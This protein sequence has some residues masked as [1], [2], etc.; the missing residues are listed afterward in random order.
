MN[1]NHRLRYLTWLPILR[2][3]RKTKLWQSCGQY[4]VVGATQG[5]RHLQGSY[6]F[7]KKIQ[8]FP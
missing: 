5:I 4:A 3:K 8:D 2:V 7:S 1:P 6:S